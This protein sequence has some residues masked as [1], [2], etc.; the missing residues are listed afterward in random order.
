VAP[1]PA[2][3]ASPPTPRASGPAFRWEW[4]A[5][6]AVSLLLI[7]AALY[8]RSRARGRT[9]RT[10]ASVAAPPVPVVTVRAAGG[11]TRTE[12]G[13]E[14]PVGEGRVKIGFI[15]GDP[16]T[17]EPEAGAAALAPG[18]VVVRMEDEVGE[19]L[20]AH[21]QRVTAGG[22]MEVRVAAAEPA[23]TRDEGAVILKRR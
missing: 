9:A 21:P 15:M 4:L 23:L 8:L 14:T 16:R 10:A 18:R 13:P 2:A 22:A 20:G 19:T 7:A 17:P 5:G 1:P 3:D 12:S 11:E 6:L